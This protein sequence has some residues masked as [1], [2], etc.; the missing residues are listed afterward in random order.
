[1]F[2]MAFNLLKMWRHRRKYANL[3]QNFYLY[4]KIDIRREAQAEKFKI[5]DLLHKN[6]E[7]M[8]KRF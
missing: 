5:Q 7:G 4:I 1:M 6:S 2:A 8:Q 3:P